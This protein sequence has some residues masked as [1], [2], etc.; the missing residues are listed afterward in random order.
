MGGTASYRQLTTETLL[1]GEAHC[2]E[3]ESSRVGRRAIL[4]RT[5]GT[6]LGV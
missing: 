5:A 1:Q 4:S 3:V 6:E 2:L